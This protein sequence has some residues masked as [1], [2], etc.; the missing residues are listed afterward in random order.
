MRGIGAGLIGISL[1]LA[2]CG[3]TP[4]NAQHGGDSTGVDLSSVKIG[5][6]VEG[7]AKS[8][9]TPNARFDQ[10]FRNRLLN[11]FNPDGLPSSPLYELRVLLT[12]TSSEVGIQPD[13][14]SAR[15]DVSVTAHYDL[16]K[17]E[18]G[19]PVISGYSFG[20]NSYPIITN[21]YATLVGG[22]DAQK[23]AVESVAD[24]IA[25]RV[26]LYFHGRTDQDQ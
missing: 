18:T 24:D 9:F 8:N 15:T 16:I 4:L 23:R 12:Q 10:E 6:V 7:N 26:A 11:N 5:P 21:S 3:F 20:I 17:L 22:Q 2:G 13:G 1:L 25:R 19:K 14:S